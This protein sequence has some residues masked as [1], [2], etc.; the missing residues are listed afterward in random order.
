ML[1]TRKAIVEEYRARCIRTAVALGI[2][3][4]FEHPHPGRSSTS[5]NPR[6]HLV[7]LRVYPVLP[8]R[9]DQGHAYVPPLAGGCVASLWTRIHVHFG[10]DPPVYLIETR[11]SRVQ[12]FI[13]RSQRVPVHFKSVSAPPDVLTALLPAISNAQNV[14]L[15]FRPDVLD[16]FSD[17]LPSS[18]PLSRSTTLRRRREPL[19][20]FDE[21]DG[22]A[23]GYQ[24]YTVHFF[25][26]PRALPPSCSRLRSMRCMSTSP[27]F[28][29]GCIPHFF[30]STGRSDSRS[31]PKRPPFVCHGCSGCHCTSAS[32]GAPGAVRCLFPWSPIFR[33]VSRHHTTHTSIHSPCGKRF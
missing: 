5:R 18:A 9:V 16:T 17:S 28:Q 23:C 32:T 22:R 21:D 11:I 3:L 33:V 6:P 25:F 26:I 4:N 10:Y 19:R 30:D 29:D 15:A 24:Q 13:A 12:E 27:A 14:Y 2:S 20:G 31:T 8:P 7:V 1:S